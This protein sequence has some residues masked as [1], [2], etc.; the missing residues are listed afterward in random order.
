LQ[1]RDIVDGGSAFTRLKQAYVNCTSETFGG[2]P[3]ANRVTVKGSF[4]KKKKQLRLTWAIYTS[5]AKTETL[6]AEGLAVKR[7]G[8]ALIITR[9]ITKDITTLRTDVNQALTARQFAKYKAAAF[10]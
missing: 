1:F 4:L 9:S 3:P 6:R 7:A 8:G 5:S 2:T 10:S